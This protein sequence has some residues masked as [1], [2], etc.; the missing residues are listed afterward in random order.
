[1]LLNFKTF[2]NIYF[3]MSLTIYGNALRLGHTTISPA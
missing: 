1:M 3:A 2:N